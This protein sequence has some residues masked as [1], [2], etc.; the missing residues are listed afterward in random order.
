M[1][2]AD[3]PVEFVLVD[4]GVLQSRSAAIQIGGETR[5]AFSTLVFQNITIQQS[6][7]CVS[8]EDFRHSK[9]SPLW[10][11]SLVRRRAGSGYIGS[12]CICFIECLRDVV[13]TR[14]SSLYLPLEAG[15]TTCIHEGVACAL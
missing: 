4:G 15:F 1:R 12:S 2:A 3:K 6:H 13:T 7:R 11:V 5:G 9:G 10:S 8:L 14:Y